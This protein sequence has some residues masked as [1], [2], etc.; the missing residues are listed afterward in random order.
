MRLE[1]ENI[2]KHLLEKLNSSP[3]FILFDYS[4]MNA[5]DFLTLRERLGELGAECHIAK[6]SYVKQVFNGKNLIDLKEILVGQNAYIAGGEDVCGAT[7][8]LVKFGKEFEKTEIKGGI[9]DGKELSISEIKTLAKLPSREQL[10][11]QLLS[12]INSPASQTVAVLNQ[13]AQS[14]LRLISTKFE[15]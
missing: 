4:Q 14:L 1:K 8:I 5:V 10:L 3:Y 2:V 6:N 9:L 11:A 15:L 12:T 7:K 13:P